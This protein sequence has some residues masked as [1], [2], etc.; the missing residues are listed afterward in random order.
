MPN[1]RTLMLAAG[2]LLLSLVPLQSVLADTLPGPLIPLPLEMTQP[3]LPPPTLLDGRVSL[4]GGEVTTS[5]QQYEY[6]SS[7]QLIYM[8]SDEEYQARIGSGYFELLQGPY[9]IVLAKRPYVLPSTAKFVNQLAAD[10]FVFGCGKLV[11][12]S[13]GRLS[14]ERPSNGSIYSVHPFGLAVDL[15]TRFI[16][17]ECADWL[18][19]YVSAKEASQEVDGT[20]EHHPEHLHVVVLIQKPEPILLAT[21]P[22]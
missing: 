4:V 20:Q 19:S 1:L 2:L 11:V 15:R 9:L 16:P 18:R 12:T 3:P 10:Y 13:A 6:A 22:K 14:T 21:V 8:T 17:T 5:Q 7:H